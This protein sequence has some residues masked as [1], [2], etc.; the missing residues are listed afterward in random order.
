MRIGPL[1]SALVPETAAQGIDGSA[2][3]AKPSY[4]PTEILT[5]KDAQPCASRWRS[6]RSWG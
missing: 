3:F 1:A 4:L 5:A 2:F 6:V